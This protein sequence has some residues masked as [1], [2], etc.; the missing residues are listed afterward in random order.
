MLESVPL[1]A[2]GTAVPADSSSSSTQQH[3]RSWRGTDK[4]RADDRYE[5]MLMLQPEE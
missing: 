3:N 2:L 1:Y 5:V 4:A